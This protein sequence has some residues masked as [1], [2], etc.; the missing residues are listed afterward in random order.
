MRLTAFRIGPTAP[1]L[2]AAPPAREWMDQTPERFAY[3]CLPL[4]IANTHGWEIL[5]PSSIEV[6][7]NG[8]AGLNTMQV[9]PAGNPT[10]PA[11]AWAT[12]HFGSGVL[13]FHTGY[14]FRTEPGY[15]LVATGPVNAPRDGAA[16]LTGL[17]ETDW[18]PQPFTMNWLFTA[19]GGPVLF[20]EGEPFC[21][22]FP[23][24]RDLVEATEPEI[25]DL[26]SDPELQQRYEQW[27][28]SRAAFNRDL[29]VKGSAAQDEKW[30]KHY[31]RGRHP[32]GTSGTDDHH[33]K[34]KLREF[35]ER[36]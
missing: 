1:R 15:G 36:R 31:A 19:P 29:Q 22:V 10:G 7:W 20:E 33:T 16:A 5:C 21:H 14:L 18:L 4:T 27:A 13:T 23:V 28:A 11:P 32:D 8:G 2:R 3:R 17:V 26:A 30:Q 9:V 34:L 12:S 6:Y 25:R 24:R 35:I